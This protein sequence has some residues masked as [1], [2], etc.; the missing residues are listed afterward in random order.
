MPKKKEEPEPV[1]DEPAE[2]LETAK[3]HLQ[4]LYE[5]LISLN[6]RSISDLENL[7]ARS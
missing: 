5:E 1:S 4:A 7:I 6:V 3:E 2:R